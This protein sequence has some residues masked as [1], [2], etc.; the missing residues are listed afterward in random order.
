M[1]KLAKQH[2]DVTCKSVVIVCMSFSI[3]MH[4]LYLG[5]HKESVIEIAIFLSHAHLDT[6]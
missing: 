1:G 5:M 4:S 2:V 3:N 6:L